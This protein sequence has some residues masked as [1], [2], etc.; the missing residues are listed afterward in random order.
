MSN[1]LTAIGII[2]AIPIASF[3]SIF[4]YTCLKAWINKQL[5]EIDKE[6][7][8]LIEKMFKEK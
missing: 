8:E 3:L 4:F 5:D 7:D 2:L 6:T 1:V